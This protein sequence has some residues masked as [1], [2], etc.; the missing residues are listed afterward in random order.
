MFGRKKD[1]QYW[2]ETFYKGSVL[3]PGWDN[4]K[5]EILSIAPDHEK[6]KLADRVDTLGDKISREWAESNEQRVINSSHLQ[7]WGREIKTAKAENYASLVA[8]LKA[9]EDEV[10]NLLSQSQA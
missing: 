4:V 5:D 3:I 6:E 10:E 8:R 9:V 7:T 2:I 1:Y